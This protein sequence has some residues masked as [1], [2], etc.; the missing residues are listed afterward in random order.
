MSGRTIIVCGGRTY[1][2]RRFVYETLDAEH[3][4][5]P[6]GFVRHGGATG[7]DAH[8]SAWASERGIPSQAYLPLWSKDGRA[9]G[10]IRNEKMAR[11]GADICIAFPGGAGTRSMVALARQ[12]GISVHE[13]GR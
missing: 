11:E 4:T 12:Y 8:A 9:A 13:V 10:P 7:A 3:A 1:G 5:Q 6:I 2:D